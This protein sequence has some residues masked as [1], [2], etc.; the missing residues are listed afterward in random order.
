MR[1]Q[2]WAARRLPAGPPA[3][4]DHAAAVVQRVLAALSGSVVF[5]LPER[6]PLGEVTDFRFATASP[7]AVDVAGRHGPDLVGRSVLETYPG[8]AGTDLWRGYLRALQTGAGYEGDLEYEETAAGIPRLSRYRVRAVPCEGGLIVSWERLDR[9]EREQR[10]LALMQRLG[11]MGW[12]DRDLVRGEVTWSDEVYSVFGRDRPAGPLTL[13]ALAAQAVS[14]DRP[15]LDDA[16]RRLLGSGE[17][18]DHTFRIQLPSSEVR[19]VRVVSEAETDALGRPVHLHGFFQDITAA[20]HAEQQLLEQQQ[21]AL[22]QQLLLT[23]ERDLAARLQDTLLP[24]PQQTLHLAGLTVDVAYQPLQE[25]LNLG[26]DWYSAIELPDGNALLVVGDVAGHGLD[27]VATMALLRF[28]AKGMA[29]TGTPL[30][31]ILTRLNTLLL[32]TAD[33]ESRTATMIMAVYQPAASRLT[34][35]RAGHLPPLLLRA[36]EARLLP[37][38]GGILLGATATPHYDAATLDLLPGDHLLLYT[39]GLV[40]TPEEPIDESLARLTRTAP[41][42]AGAPDFLTSLMQALARPGGRHD[43]VCALHISR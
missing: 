43:D 2:E 41:A 6:G 15:E 20:K 13:E 19:H 17:P 33:R 30:P 37:A 9:A 16:I 35:V 39:D 27:A 7:D 3:Q 31:T 8:V 25:G 24:V 5:L 38:P 10:R 32:H 36:G 28:T 40:E 21:H 1:E 11:R 29:I 4:D 14:E 26:G 18:V 12:V 34:W 22:A 42:H 23:A